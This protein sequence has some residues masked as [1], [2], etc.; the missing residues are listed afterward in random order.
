MLLKQ[1]SIVLVLKP[2]AAHYSKDLE[3]SEKLLRNDHGPINE[4]VVCDN[5]SSYYM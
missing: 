2:R 3:K 4:S 5:S 1:M